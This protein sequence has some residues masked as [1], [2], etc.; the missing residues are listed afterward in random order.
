MKPKISYSI[1]MR[2]LKNKEISHA[3]DIFKQ[4]IENDPNDLK[5]RF[6]LAKLYYDI[7]E[8]FKSRATFNQ[9]VENTSDRIQTFIELGKNCIDK[10]NFEQAT[11]ALEDAQK[12]LTPNLDAR[13]FLKLLYKQAGEYDK[14]SIL[15]EEEAIITDLEFRSQFDLGNLRSK[16]FTKKEAKQYLDS[17]MRPHTRHLTSDINF[18]DLLNTNFETLD[19]SILPSFI[20][21]K[22]YVSDWEPEFLEEQHSENRKKRNIGNSPRTSDRPLIRR[23]GYPQQLS[24]RNRVKHLMEKKPSRGFQGKDKFTGYIIFEY[25]DSG[26]CV[27]EKLFTQTKDKKI[28]E[29]SSNATYIFPIGMTLSLSQYSK[30]DIISMMKTQSYIKRVV[31][32]KNYYKNLEKAMKDVNFSYNKHRKAIGLD[33]IVPDSPYDDEEQR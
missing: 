1:G 15:E 7:N 19:F 33:N 28:R 29:S 20:S 9:I 6:A 21:N 11:D 22:P 4:L 30:R 5:S 23:S 16:N 18:L 24:I 31:H 2:A 26:V 27:L 12:L 32:S 8:P 10:N 25:E 3:E 17:F 13:S 14:L